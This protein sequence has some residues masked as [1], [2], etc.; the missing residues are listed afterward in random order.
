MNNI[1]KQQMW[2]LWYQGEN[3]LNVVTEV[4]NDVS[5]LDSLTSFR[6]MTNWSHERAFTPIENCLRKE[7]KN[8]FK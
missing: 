1:I 7:Y 8:F 4:L 2:Y 6:M 5:N 3:M